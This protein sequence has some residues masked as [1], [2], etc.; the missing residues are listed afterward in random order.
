M[1]CH[2][3]NCQARLVL[4]P[5]ELLQRADY[6]PTARSDLVAALRVMGVSEGGVLMAHVRMSALGW[7]VGGM[8]AIVGAA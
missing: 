4:V 1:A 5:Q 7:M 2:R 6:R 3:S 8:D